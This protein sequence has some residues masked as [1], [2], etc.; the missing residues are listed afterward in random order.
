[1]AINIA[2]RYIYRRNISARF[3]IKE[4]KI[5]HDISQ[6]KVLLHQ[7]VHRKELFSKMTEVN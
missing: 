2:E 1:M 7:Q 5:V 4:R 3:D 6:N